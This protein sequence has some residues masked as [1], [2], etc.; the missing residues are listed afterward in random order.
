ML[1]QLQ[2]TLDLCG[3]DL[4]DFDIQVVLFLRGIWVP[5]GS[6]QI[7]FAQKEFVFTIGNNV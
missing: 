3:F 4:R 7:E 5:T 6:A 2:V 1:F